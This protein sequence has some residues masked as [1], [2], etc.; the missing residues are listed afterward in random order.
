MKLRAFLSLIL[1]GTI[2]FLSG[3][4]SS[5]PY[6]ADQGPTA[7]VLDNGVRYGSILAAG[8][9]GYLLGKA[10]TGSTLGGAAIGGAA[11][12]ATY[13]FNKYTDAKRGE[14]YNVGYSDGTKFAREEIV[15]EVYRREAIYGIQPTV[16]SGPGSNAGTN[17]Q[18]EIR[19]VYV[20]ER[21]INGVVYPAT[22]Q[23]TDVYK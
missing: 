23:T 22:T 1:A 16:I 4:A 2:P 17:G 21:N 10:A 3:C 7:Q 6:A 14:A 20:P 15:N 12:L 9:G 13:G 19:Q 11:A 18:P 8:G 5:A